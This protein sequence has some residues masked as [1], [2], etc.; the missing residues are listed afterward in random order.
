MVYRY[1]RPIFLGRYQ[2]CRDNV[3][4]AMQIHVPSNSSL[5]LHLYWCDICGHRYTPRK[6]RELGGS[7][8]NGQP[9]SD[10]HKYSQKNW[11]FSR[12]R[13]LKVTFRLDPGST[14]LG[15]FPT[16]LFYW[17]FEGPPRNSSSF[18]KCLNTSAV[19]L[20]FIELHWGGLFWTGSKVSRFH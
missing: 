19:F 10:I 12:F 8:P 3:I 20:R 11:I 2:I 1:T 4:I 18:E 14:S 9:R 17:F 16:C 7:Q 13:F 6:R 15:Q 5:D